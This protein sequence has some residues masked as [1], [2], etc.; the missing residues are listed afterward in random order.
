MTLPV[1]F[2]QWQDRQ[3]ICKD[4][5]AAP[6]DFCYTAEDAIKWSAEWLIERL[7]TPCS[8]R[9]HPYGIVVR[10]PNK[11]T[12]PH[13]VG[14]EPINWG[15]L[16]ASVEKQGETW[17]VTLEEASPNACPGLCAYVGDWLRKWGWTNVV[18]ETE[19]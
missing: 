11:L 13:D 1:T 9:T 16:G 18:V 6:K 3:T 15:D 10:H 4:W 5:D 8:L 17:I 14:H 2:E 7:Y 12:K 19:W